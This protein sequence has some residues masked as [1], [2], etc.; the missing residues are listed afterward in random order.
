MKIK[1]LLSFLFSIFLLSSCMI[2]DDDIGAADGNEVTYY[3][4]RT[5]WDYVSDNSFGFYYQ[6]EFTFYKNG[7]GV[8]T[9]TDYSP[10]RVD[11]KNYNFNWY[12]VDGYFK[13]ICIE[14]SPDNRIFFS[15]LRVDYYLLSGYL[16]GTYI[17]FVPY[18][19]P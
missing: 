5:K 7:S 10:G 13:D 4:C 15:D 14:Y 1:I 19:F 8:E 3:L 11:S 9:Y 6:Q 2:Q 17:E 18:D 12:F 16:D